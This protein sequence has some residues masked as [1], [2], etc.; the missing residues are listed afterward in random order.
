MCAVIILISLL[1]FNYVNW[2]KFFRIETRIVSEEAMLIT[3]KVVFVGIVLQI[4]FKIISSVLYAI[5]KSSV[6]NA[7]SLV[8][9]FLILVVLLVAPSSD[10]NHNLVF[11]GI[12]YDVSVILPY[13]GASLVVYFSKK[14]RAISPKIAFISCKHSVKVLSLGGYFFII[15][16]LYMLIMST[17]EYL[18]SF[19]T[20]SSDV[21]EYRIYFQLFTLG[22]TI[23]A[24]ALTPVWSA[25]TKAITEN[26]IRWIK[27]LYQKMII[28]A[29]GGCICIFLIIPFLQTIFNLWLGVATITVNYVTAISFAALGSLMLFNAV[30]SN[31]ANGIG[32]LGTQ[33]GVFLSGA[34]LKVPM[35]YVLINITK[36]WVA[37]VIATNVVLLAYCIAQP[38]ALHK[39]INYGMKK[40]ST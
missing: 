7:I 24:L 27:M 22:S 9:S 32:K 30:L 11:M 29:C 12:V 38:I 28:G 40:R 23:C 4:F 1:T 34:I 33:L 6:N 19:F 21:V 13:I 10:N 35:I 17:N 36:S 25:I 26:D 31:V 37:V 14:Y 18:I 16:L 8:T 5:Q 15:Q 2:N 3:V 20:N 39:Y